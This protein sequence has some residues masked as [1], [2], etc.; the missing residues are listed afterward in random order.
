M[1]VPSFLGEFA[2]VHHFVP[3]I[4]QT[5]NSQAYY[6]QVAYRLPWFEKKWKPYYRFEHIHVPW[7]PHFLLRRNNDHTNDSSEF[8]ELDGINGGR[9][10]RHHRFRRLQERISQVQRGAN[11]PWFNGAF[12]QTAFTF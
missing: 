3:Q 4:G 10:L 12:V 8:S 11:Q 7:G 9:P 5:F 2:N 1:R 6:L